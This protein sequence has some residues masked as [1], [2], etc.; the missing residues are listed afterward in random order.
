[1]ESPIKSPYNLVLTFD[2]LARWN[3]LRTHAGVDHPLTM[4]DALEV[5]SNLGPRQRSSILETLGGLAALPAV[6]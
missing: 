2:M 4:D 5:L 6:A 1:M 3:E